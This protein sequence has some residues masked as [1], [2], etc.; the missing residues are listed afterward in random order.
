MHKFFEIIA[1]FILQKKKCEMIFNAISIRF[2]NSKSYYA[3][4]DRSE[5]FRGKGICKFHIINYKLKLKINAIAFVRQSSSGTEIH[6]HTRRV[7][8]FHIQ[9]PT[10]LFQ[11]VRSDLVHFWWGSLTVNHHHLQ[12]CIRNFEINIVFWI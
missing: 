4:I 12:K 9:H 8:H 3:K 2:G 7:F 5:N 6:W 1:L 11:L 10:I